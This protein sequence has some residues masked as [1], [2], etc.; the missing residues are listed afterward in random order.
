MLMQMDFSNPVG[1]GWLMNHWVV[2]MEK[3]LR[4]VW[5]DKGWQADLQEQ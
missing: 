1:F 5:P 2:V 3:C 4:N